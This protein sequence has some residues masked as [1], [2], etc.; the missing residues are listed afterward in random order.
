VASFRR[1]TQSAIAGL[2]LALTTLGA[3]NDEGAQLYAVRCATCHGVRG[4][5]STIAP[6]LAGASAADVHF[7]LD[8]GRMPAASPFTGEVH[9]SPVFT[10]E[11]MDRIVD[12][13]ESLS[14]RGDRSIPQVGLGPADLQRG[15]Q[16]FIANCAPCHGTV[17]QGDSV[18]RDDVAPALGSATVFQVA[19]A[20]RAGPSVMPRFGRDVLSDRDVTDIARY[21]NYVQTAGGGRDGIDPGGFTLAHVGPVAEGFVAWFFGIGFLVLFLRKIGTTE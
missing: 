20:I 13:V 10:F 7:M 8:T 19:E 4:E 9:M 14:P 5:G 18:G 3:A 15:A 6:S 12:Y 11:Q 2:V 1:C 17:G 21:V 16:L